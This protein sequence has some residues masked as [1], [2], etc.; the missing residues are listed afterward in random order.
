M[1]ENEPTRNDTEDTEGA[2]VE[3]HVLDSQD[4]GPS[5]PESACISVV[6]SIEER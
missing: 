5:T 6:S 4:L 1:A 2:E 3:G